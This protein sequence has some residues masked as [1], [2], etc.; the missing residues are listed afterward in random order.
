[1]KLTKDN[2]STRGKTCPSTTLSNTNPTWTDPGSNTGL[3]GWR[4]ATN[5][6][7]HGTARL[8][9]TVTLNGL[10]L[11]PEANIYYLLNINFV[12]PGGRAVWHGYSSLCLLCVL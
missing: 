6:L 10:V 8:C 9:V 5:R 3:R 11:Q 1:M 7:S 2:R 12:D 4:P